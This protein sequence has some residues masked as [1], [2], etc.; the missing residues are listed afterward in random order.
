MKKWI[1]V[2]VVS[3]I[4]GYIF[5]NWFFNQPCKPPEKPKNIPSVAIWKGGCDGGNWIELVS[6]E[7]D[8]A[9]FKIYRDW[10]GELLLDADFKYQECYNINLT[11]V[12]WVDCVGDFINGIIG[13]KCDD[14]AE[15]RL[16][17][18][19]PVYYEEKD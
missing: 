17:P 2:L 10:N 18:N 19:Y 8:K 1:I 6:T 5:V 4:L 15:C 12:N 16:E 14:K 11:K 3:I 9:R 7:K 13:I